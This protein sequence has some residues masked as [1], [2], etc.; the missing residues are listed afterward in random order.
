M[1]AGGGASFS[2][3][4]R[5]RLIETR[6]AVTESI[7]RRELAEAL[8]S[9]FAPAASLQPVRAY[10][11]GMAQVADPDAPLKG[12]NKATGIVTARAHEDE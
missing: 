11:Q 3:G 7:S 2:A 4:P 6:P 8:E 10:G 9:G 5:R 12:F 1:S